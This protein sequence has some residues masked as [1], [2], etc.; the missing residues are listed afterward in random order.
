M[1][2]GIPNKR[3]TGEFKQN[4]IET[5]QK[6][7]LSYHEAAR[8]FE[9]CDHKRVANWERIYLEQGVEGLYVDRRGRSIGTQKGRPPKLDKKI[10]EDLIAENQRLR[11]ENDYL[12]KLNALVSERVQREKKR[13]S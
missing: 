9:V 10:E 11:A 12:K 1:P 6:E 3:Y 13:K 8:Q 2:K 5:M 7:K 4:V